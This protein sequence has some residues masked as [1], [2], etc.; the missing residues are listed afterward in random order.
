MH[1]QMLA[2]S[3]HYGDEDPARLRA[4]VGRGL[5]K[6]TVKY[7]L[8]CGL[9]KLSAP[10]WV[11]GVPELGLE[12]RLFIPIRCN[13]M[14]LGF[15][16]LIDKGTSLPNTVIERAVRAA[17]L[18]GLVL[19]RKLMFQEWERKR[20]E[21]ILRDLISTEETVRGRTIREIEEGSLIAGIRSSNGHQNR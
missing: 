16:A 15:L 9:A 1:M 8:S 18:A 21:A 4:L 12:T 17:E 19:Y 20:E 10:K 6:P 11:G 5:D 13:N 14:P 2:V 3:A 7:L